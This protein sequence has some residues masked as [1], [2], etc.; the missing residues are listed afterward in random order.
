MPISTNGA[1]ITRLAGALYGEY[2]SNASYT[3]VS[4]TAPA[5]VAANWLTNDFAGKTD[6]QVANTILSNLGLTSITGLNNWLSAQLT[7]AGSSA[8]AKGAALVSILNGYANMTTDA[9]YGSYAVGFNAKVD[10]SL[11]L[12]QTAGAKG[13]SFATSDV[14]AVTPKTFTLTTGVNSGAAFTG[15][16]GSDSFD[17][18]LGGSGAN[19]Q[20]L[21]SADSLDGGLG[22][23][24]LIAT[25][26]GNTTSPTLAGIESITATAT[27][28]ATL[29]LLNSTG[30]TSL[31]NA[32]STAALSFANIASTSV[33]L[34]DTNNASGT[35]FGYTTA[36]VAGTADSATLTLTN[37]T[38]GTE[39]INGVETVNL[40]SSGSANSITLSADAA[41]TVGVTGDQNLTLGT[42]GSTVTNVNAGTFTGRL[43][44]TTANATAATVTGGTANDTIT[45][46]A[47]NDNISGGAGADSLTGG[48][49]NDVLSGGAGN[50]T[51]VGGTEN[52]NI[53]GGDDADTLVFTTLSAM[54]GNGT[55][56]GGAG[57]DTLRFTGDI[58]ADIVE[59]TLVNTRVSGVEAIDVRGANAAA[60]TITLTDAAL[61][62]QG[63][64]SFTVTDGVYSDAATNNITVNAGA[65]TAANSVDAAFNNRAAVQVRITTGAGANTDT[66]TFAVGTSTYATYTASGSITAA[67]TAAGLAAAINAVTTG[68]YVASVLNTDYVVIAATNPGSSIASSPTLTS[69]GSIRINAQGAAGAVTAA[70]ADINN[71]YTGGAGADTFRVGNTGVGTTDRGLLSADT[72]AGGAGTDTLI[73]TGGTTT[74]TTVD[75][76]NVSGVE[77]I[78]T[79][80]TGLVTIN[81]LATTSI[82]ST[83]TLTVNAAS[84]TVAARGLNLDASGYTT[85]NAG[86]ISVTSGA[87]A[88]TIVGTAGSDSIDSGAGN[89]TITAGSGNDSLT[90][91]DGDD[92][93]IYASEAA[94]SDDTGLT[95]VFDTVAGGAGNDTVQFTTSAA[96]LS[97][98]QLA[99][100]T[101]VEIIDLAITASTITLSD[102][103]VDANGGD[104]QQVR[105]TTAGT[106]TASALT[107]PNSIAVRVEDAT[108]GVVSVTGGA[109]NDS[110]TF[111]GRAQGQLEATDAVKLGSG[112]D[113]IFVTNIQ[114]HTAGAA[115]G[116]SAATLS[117]LV[118]GVESLVVSDL[119][120]DQA[121]GDITITLDNTF[122]ATTFTVDGSQLDA[123]EDL[124]FTNANNT[125]ASGTGL[126]AAVSVTGGAG[127]D[128]ITGGV[129]ADTLIGGAGDDNLTG[130]VGI[131]NLSGGEGND[132][133]TVATLSHFAGLL[134]AE[135]VSGGTG[136]D[137]LTVS[138][139]GTI[140]APDLV[141]LNSVETI[142]FTNTGAINTI[143]LSD[144]VYT[145]NGL[146]SLAVTDTGTGNFGIT[147]NAA[148]LSAANSVQ[149]STANATG[150]DIL[151]G[152]SGNDTF[153]VIVDTTNT[154]GDIDSSDSIIGGAGTDTL[155]ISTVS[156]AATIAS[157]ANVS[158][159]ETI[160]ATV[161]TNGALSNAITLPSIP[162]TLVAAGATLTMNFATR[163]GAV[164]MNATNSEADGKFNITTGTG[165]DTITGG[166]GADTADGG[167]GS[168]SIS[169]GAGNDSLVG[170]AG[171]DTLV[172]GTGA[173][174]L[175]GGSGS[176]LFRIT[177]VASSSGSTIDTITDFVSADDQIEVNLDYNTIA[178]SIVVNATR[179][180]TGQASLTEAQ[181]SLSGERGQY[182]YDTAASR[183]YVNVN[184]DNLITS[185]DYSVGVNAASTAANT[186]A[187]GDVNF[188]ITGGSGADSITA[189]TG[190]DTISGG[191][192]AD[193]LYYNTGDAPTGELINGGADTDTLTV[194]T[195]TNFASASFGTVAGNTVS[196]N[197]A[198]ENIVITSGTTGTFL[199]TQL[200]GQT[201]N[202]NATA[203]TAA[204]LV[205]TGANA[206]ADFTNLT[207]TQSGGANAFDTGVD[208]VTINI[209]STTA[210]STTGTTL[211]DTING[212]DL[213]AGDTIIGG[214]GA[215]TITAG[216]GT[217]TITIGSGQ[218]TVSLTET[219]AA[220]DTLI[221]AT[222][223]AAGNANAATVT[224]FAFGA[225]ADLIDIQ[226]NLANGTTTATS[227]LAALAPVVTT[228][229]ATA[230]ANDVIF[231][232][233]GAGDILAAGTT[234]AN[235]VA[236]A[237][238]ALTSGTDFASANIATGDSLILQMNDGTN[239]FVFHYVADAT[240]ATTAAADLTLIGVFNATVVQALTGDFI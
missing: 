13:G 193:V 165:A 41:T 223:F 130:G 207:F 175:S 220:A 108:N 144:A 109:G 238:T 143:Y 240:A 28:T 149:I 214:T 159:I 31:E 212:T 91:G 35:T 117:S 106:V 75:M 162:D 101:G 123:G 19:L 10:A 18:S 172:G 224:G 237:V 22:S 95:L 53:S 39:T 87:G 20:T 114:G 160:N 97:A 216:G 84:Q 136:N 43:S 179:A 94:Y 54:A 34:K 198:I 208:T 27:G 37:V 119:A 206:T 158:G 107:A 79:S 49:G 154:L 121:N 215:D 184:N 174:T 15:G 78:T 222:A 23:D 235:A 197:A 77:N 125:T 105:L 65:L 115:A 68:T 16:T 232:L 38:A 3:E 180:T 221:W 64:T 187:A 176:D 71:S 128:A 51:I 189:G 229:N 120:T 9:V 33:A 93:F 30:Y 226:V 25:L 52:D 138:D 111:S 74:T 202:I 100:L 48:A 73:V 169:G 59:S 42:L 55:V 155:T 236:N 96:T 110:V 63:T 227:T 89:D 153:T 228:S 152:G 173:D 131:D 186:I 204:N 40:V 203:A 182:I 11:A 83:G 124:T 82:A 167:S 46:G 231:T 56:S 76:R 225:G 156:A 99:G 151:T 190:A 112:T 86:K 230:T 81:A 50:D 164:I 192:G 213:A 102:A 113:T 32:N 14:V 166:S 191:A 140:N 116:A 90:G 161:G 133:F 2:L 88:D 80:G 132:T 6:L 44:V 178:S 201:I 183:L 234:I 217:D 103:V 157:L 150:D 181:N 118:T 47:G 36:A 129:Q 104:V 194:V 122:T 219:T 85:T 69:A 141:G 12:S 5:T 60:R 233:N 7:A 45:G 29:S 195:S 147:V 135:T 200:T 218:D 168:D 205:I 61:A 188:S 57:T 66:I 170:N 62:S 146:T 92:T 58:G 1:I 70:T 127:N 26:T 199:A 134:Q 67:A 139:S 142:T 209:G 163:T 24:V 145:A 126:A 17:G 211:A 196:T 21:N 171:D 8:A 210:A 4:T 98:A 239:T 185:L 148:G 137:T 72:L 177:T